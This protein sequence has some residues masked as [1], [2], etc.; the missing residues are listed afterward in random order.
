MA[1]RFEFILEGED[2]SRLRAAAEDAIEEVHLWHRRLSAF[3]PGSDV[4]R[5]NANAAASPV[6]VDSELFALLSLCQR[7][8]EITGGAFDPAIGAA[9][10]AG[11][12]RGAPS[13][14]EARAAANS[15]TGFRHVSLDAANR[16]VRFDREGI[17]L[18]LGAIGKGWALDRAAERLREA[19]IAAAFLHGG[20]S[21]A[22]AFGPPGSAGWRVAISRET[23]SPLV[24]LVN[25]G[26]GVSSPRG[27]VVEGRGHVL[28]PRTGDSVSGLLVAAVATGTGAEA[29]GLSTALL[30]DGPEAPWIPEGVGAMTLSAEHEAAWRIR[31]ASATLIGPDSWA[32]RPA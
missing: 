30:V 20:T 28:D 14:T 1:T 4:S 12:F 26:L 11:G 3:E 27:R 9:M 23:G 8:W 7:L 5:I 21:S 18:D 16:T 10:K 32:I 6:R 24:E 17:A 19:G 2:A 25:G 22:V 15:A 13:T 29:D 31:P